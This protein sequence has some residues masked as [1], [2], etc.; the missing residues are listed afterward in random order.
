M[1]LFTRR[2]VICSPG[3]VLLAAVLLLP[4]MTRTASAERMSFTSAIGQSGSG[5]KLGQH[6]SLMAGGGEEILQDSFATL[7]DEFDELPRFPHNGNSQTARIVARAALLVVAIAAAGG[8]ALLSVQ[9][10]W[11]QEAEEQQAEEKPE[12]QLHEDLVRQYDHLSSS[13]QN[14]TL[15][16]ELRVEHRSIPRLMQQEIVDTLEK[17][18]DDSASQESEAARDHEYES[19]MDA[20]YDSLFEQLLAAESKNLR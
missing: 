8:I 19:A 18:L 2:G 6:E 11:E 15:A 9:Q 14:K 20:A 4:S 16:E 3:A 7:E 10:G 12:D 13:V 5:A 1:R 17:E